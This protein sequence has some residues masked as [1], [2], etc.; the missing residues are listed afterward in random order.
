M[1]PSIWD[2]FWN[3]VSILS[4]IVQ[5]TLYQFIFSPI[6]CDIPLIFLMDE[7]ER[8][9]IMKELVKKLKLKDVNYLIN[10]QGDEP[11][12]DPEDIIKLN[13]VLLL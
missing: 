10:L 11:M 7:L 3:I 12:I 4:W 13:N 5:S 1:I 2:S 6:I 8:L 9:S